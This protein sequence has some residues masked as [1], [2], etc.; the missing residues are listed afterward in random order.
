MSAFMTINIILAFISQTLGLLIGAVFAEDFTSAVYAAALITAPLLLFCGFLVPFGDMPQYLHPISYISWFRYTMEA[1]VIAMYGFDRCE[2]NNMTLANSTAVP[3]QTMPNMNKMLQ[4]A[5]Y[6]NE[7]DMMGEALWMLNQGIIDQLKTGGSL[8]IKFFELADHIFWPDICIL[9]A[10][11]ITLRF[12][13][14]YFLL[15]KVNRNK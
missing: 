14:Y 9:L 3:L 8:V 15:W 5:E 6:L 1:I 12:M 2:T 10:F 11:M 7:N 4:L 13:G